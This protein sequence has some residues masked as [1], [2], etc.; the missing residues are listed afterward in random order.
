M[1]N[2]FLIQ[3]DGSPSYCRLDLGDLTMV[4]QVSA[5]DQLFI[6]DST[7]FA[8]FAVSTTPEPY[9]WRSGNFFYPRPENFAAGVIDA[10]GTGVV[11]IYADDVLR[12]E[13]EFH[14]LTYF[15]LRSG[16]SCY[17]WAVEIEGD[18]IVRKVDLA[19][20]FAELKGV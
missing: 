2:G 8:E 11:R 6:G 10:R 3:L 17:R 5:S 14:D 1:A 13:V 7:G 9:V 12:E 18:A 15:R 19:R 20:S 16:P 4:Q